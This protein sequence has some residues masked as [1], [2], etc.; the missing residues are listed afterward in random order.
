M[1]VADGGETR[2]P[3]PGALGGGRHAV[4]E[5]TPDA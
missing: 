5:Q 1:G 3:Q 4:S 2:L